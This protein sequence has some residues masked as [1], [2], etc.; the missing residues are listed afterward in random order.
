MLHWQKCFFDTNPIYRRG[1]YLCGHQY[2]LCKQHFDQC[3]YCPT[4]DRG[5]WKMWYLESGNGPL[6]RMNVKYTCGHRVSMSEE[7]FR[8]YNACPILN[9]G[10]TKD[11]S[12]Y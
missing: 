9:D 6:T 1:Q 4:G 8:R 7:D 2:D 12:E 11:I 5:H 3:E 10:G